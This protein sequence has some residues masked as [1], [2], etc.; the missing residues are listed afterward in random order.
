MLG[1]Q[2][3][4]V[5]KMDVI[6]AEDA[7]VAGESLHA[8]LQRTRQALG[9]EHAKTTNLGNAFEELKAK[10]QRL[11]GELTSVRAAN[12]AGL[13]A[14][15]EKDREVRELRRDL[16]RANERVE[17]AERRVDKMLA[18][19]VRQAEALSGRKA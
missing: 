8:D 1:E 9:E 17:A 5:V 6:K 7:P 14:L 4:V 11:E 16:E 15:E 3:D 19:M 10:S 2:E 18:I 13:V 12:S